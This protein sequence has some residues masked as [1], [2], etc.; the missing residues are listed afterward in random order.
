MTEFRTPSWRPSRSF[1][2]VILLAATALLASDAHAQCPAVGAD[3]LCGI[4][5]TITDQGS[6]I[7]FTGQPP[8]SDGSLGGGN[9]TD[10]L[11]G[12]INNSSVPISSIGLSSPQTIFNFT[13]NGID[14]FG[15]PGN[16]M[17][18]SGYGGPNAYFSGI[19]V[20]S[21]NGLVNF[22]APIPPAGGTG[23]FALATN[24][25]SATTCTDLLNGAVQS[26]VSSGTDIQSFFTPNQ[27]ASLSQAATLC[28]FTSFNWQQLIANL[29]QPSPFYTVDF[30]NL[31]APL[32]FNDPPP[33]GYSYQ[34]PYANQVILPVYYNIFTTDPKD[35]LSLI[36]NQ[37][38]TTLS[39]YDSPADTCLYGS[40]TSI[41][42][43][44]APMG[45]VLSFS[46]H[47][48]GVIG[49]DTNAI[50]QDTGIGF[51]WTDNFNGTSGGISVLNATHP[52]DPGSG[53]GGVTITSFNPNTTYRY[54]R[55]LIVS[56]VNGNAAGP[57]LPERLLTAQ[58][59]AVTASGLAYSRL[60]KTFAGTVTLKN[61]S[62][63]P[64]AG[65]F[66]IVLL[67]LSSGAALT[68]ATGSFGGVPFLTV[69]GES[70]LLAGDSVTVA[71]RFSN[72]SMAPIK[73]SPASY[74]GG[75]N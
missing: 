56:S 42:G 65:P 3:T 55:S 67:G 14:S 53:T 1:A 74:V 45:A 6:A 15:I 37:T 41:C 70:T 34:Y 46:T 36:A 59:V 43:Y 72:P 2:V 52:V 64:L 49:N 21:Q 31:F 9:Y 62:N 4:V 44:T 8:Y 20:A 60:T 16:G 57:V 28:G 54:P 33:N 27:S 7:S 61:L 12:V 68:N 50:V 29:P 17:D 40:L 11:I 10:T 71:V 24:L 63:S 13:H 30:T 39:F 73:F 5:I 47:L 23:F 19:D 69:P 66:Q 25:T 51:T 48:V 35:P 38:A 18:Q 75:F 26:P 58:Q 22:L 32:A